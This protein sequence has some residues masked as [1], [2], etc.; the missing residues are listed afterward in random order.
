M[1]RQNQ[2]NKTH[3]IKQINIDSELYDIVVAKSLFESDPWA[4]EYIDGRTHYCE[5][6]SS[7]PNTLEDLAK[8]DKGTHTIYYYELPAGSQNFL[9]KGYRYHEGEVVGADVV[10]ETVSLLFTRNELESEG[11]WQEVSG[12]NTLE[13]R[14]DFSWSPTNTTSITVTYDAA[15]NR[16]CL[17]VP[18]DTHQYLELSVVEIGVAKVKQIPAAYLPTNIQGGNS[19]GIK[20]YTQPIEGLAD[21]FMLFASST[22]ENDISVELISGTRDVYKLNL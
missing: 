11:W 2:I 14:E 8:E 19:G 7:T 21:T 6:A 22:N 5:Y 1:T 17:A 18:N 20:F 15:N 9:L 16:L 13:Q 4:T 3:Q 12:F 10:K